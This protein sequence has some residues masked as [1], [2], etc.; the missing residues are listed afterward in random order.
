LPQASRCCRL[1][2]ELFE[3]R[4]SQKAPAAASHALR[5]T[6]REDV[7]FVARFPCDGGARKKPLSLQTHEKP[8]P[9]DTIVKFH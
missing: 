3:M 5:A 6:H 8:L 1:R 9:D 7:Q 2:E 4:R